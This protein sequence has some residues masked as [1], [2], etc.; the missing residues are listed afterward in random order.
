MKNG[1]I[2]NLSEYI[3]Y[4]GPTVFSRRQIM[5]QENLFAHRS[6][7]FFTPSENIPSAYIG[8]GNIEIVLPVV[9]PDLMDFS[10]IR[11]YASPKLWVDLL[12]Q[13]TRFIR[14]TPIEKARV[15]IIRRDV[16]ELRDDHYLGGAK[17]LRDALKFKTTGRKDRFLLYYW[18]AIRDDDSNNSNFIYEQ[19]KVDN[20]QKIGMI[21]K[22][23][24]TQ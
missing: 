8:N 24:S 16:V 7:L 2:D 10:T 13:A 22:I 21:I 4:Y 3:Y 20:I 14:W 5:K 12:Q 9:T 18:G 23:S 6:A 19:E 1:T 15:V 17:A 11:A